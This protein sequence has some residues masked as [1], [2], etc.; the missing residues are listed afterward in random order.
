ML[1]NEIIKK[2][3]K[4]YYFYMIREQ[5]ENTLENSFSHFTTCAY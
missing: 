2:S 3:I 1:K 4:S 5:L